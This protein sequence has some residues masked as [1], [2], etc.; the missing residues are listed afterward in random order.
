MLTIYQI[1]INDFTFTLA[2]Y[3]KKQPATVLIFKILLINQD[4]LREITN[5]VVARI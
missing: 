4:Y 3:C 2:G 1:R 5:A